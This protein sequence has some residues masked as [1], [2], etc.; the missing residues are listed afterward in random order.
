MPLYKPYRT[1]R[2]ACEDAKTKER[3]GWHYHPDPP[4][5]DKLWIQIEHKARCFPVGF[6]PKLLDQ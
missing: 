5:T 2:Q 6:D 1:L 4:P 3:T